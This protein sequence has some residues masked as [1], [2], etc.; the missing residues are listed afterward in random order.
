MDFLAVYNTTEEEVTTVVNGSFF[1]WKPGQ[2]KMM[3]TGQAEF[4]DSNR[5]ETGLMKIDDPRF[6]QAEDGYVLGFDKS[7]EGKKVLAPLREQGI[8]N[9]IDHLLYIIRNNQ[10]S[11]RQDL[12]NKYP[13]GDSA[14]MA[15][16]Y[17]S[18]SELEAM[19]LVVKYKRKTNDNAAKQIDEVEKLMQEIGP[20]SA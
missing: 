18:P 6:I 7:E 9:L 1:S 2:I 12:A 15:A 8:K 19:R 17:A 13:T 16:A 11:L 14:K 4:I 10:I 20:F 5:K 3:R